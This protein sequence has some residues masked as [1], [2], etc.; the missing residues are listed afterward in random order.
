MFWNTIDQVTYSVCS[1]TYKGDN[2]Y[3]SYLSLNCI[4]F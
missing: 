4:S 2:Y 1:V 3:F